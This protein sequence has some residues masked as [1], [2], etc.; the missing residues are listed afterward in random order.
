MRWKKIPAM[1]TAQRKS[2][3]FFPDYL[4]NRP[5]G[6]RL[7]FIFVTVMAHSKNMTQFE[8]ASN[9]PISRSLRVL[10]GLWAISIPCGFRMCPTVSERFCIYGREHHLTGVGSGSAILASSWLYV[11]LINRFEYPF[12]RNWCRTCAN[13]VFLFSVVLQCVP[14]PFNSVL[15]QLRL[16]VKRWLLL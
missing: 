6:G 8:W 12:S 11:R 3:M 13:S 9:S 15:S 5:R 10:L 1:K 16:G 4:D 14:T 7:H 2:I